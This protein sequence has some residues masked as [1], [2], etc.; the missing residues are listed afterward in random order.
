MFFCVT[1]LKGRVLA[2]TSQYHIYHNTWVTIQYRYHK[3]KY[4]DTLPYRFLSTAL[5]CSSLLKTDNIETHSGINKD[6]MGPINYEV[7]SIIPQ[8][9][10]MFY[11]SANTLMTSVPFSGTILIIHEQTFQQTLH[12]VELTFTHCLKGESTTCTTCYSS[13]FQPKSFLELLAERF[14]AQRNTSQSQHSYISHKQ[15]Q[16]LHVTWHSV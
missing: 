15:F 3:N 10:L 16:I 14:L 4:R 1:E 6:C 11:H 9:K 8:R 7:K 2:A 5:L 12:V 13:I